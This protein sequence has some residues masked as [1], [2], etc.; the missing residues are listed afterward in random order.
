M[1]RNTFA[2]TKEYLILLAVILGVYIG[3]KYLSPLVTPFLFAF[4]FISVLHPF[5]DK[6]YEKFHIKKSFLAAGILL[7]LCLS[8]GAG[9]WGLIVLIFRKAGELLGQIDIFEEKF[10]VFISGCCDGIEKRFGVDGDGIETYIMDRV[11]IFVDNLQIQIVPKLM[12]E[13]LGYV[14]NIVGIVSFLVIMI[15]ASVL[16][17][18][19]YRK[20][21]EMLHKRKEL[22]SV[23]KIGKKVFYHVGT[24]L[25][26]QMI[27]LFVI[28]VICSIT[29][30]VS[31]IEGGLFLGIF[32]GFMDMLPFIGTGIVLMPL[33]F[34]QVLNGYY[35][36]AVVCVIL[37]VVCA[38]TREFLE[39]KLIGEKVG[40]F[41]IGILFSVYVGVKLFGIFGI[42][43]GPLALITIYEVYR[44]MMWT[45]EQNEQMQD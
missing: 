21:M 10:C 39:P 30:V 28:G 42:I 13:S 33:A 41:P 29:L 23:I 18:K 24:F 36:K 1:D 32:I 43:K 25:K 34:W 38:I 4:A 31:G 45:K 6:A 22:K 8:V 26:A 44:Y 14:K 5:L 7:L 35:T 2:K 20:I 3:F 17:A 16:L 37:Y 12:N 19:D 11:Y 15:I 9:L 27:I 40:V